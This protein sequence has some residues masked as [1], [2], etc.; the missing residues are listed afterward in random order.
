[1]IMV[2]RFNL[3]SAEDAVWRMLRTALWGCQTSRLDEVAA[4][5]A[6]ISNWRHFEPQTLM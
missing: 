4:T 3:S 1:M 5:V 6:G 2:R